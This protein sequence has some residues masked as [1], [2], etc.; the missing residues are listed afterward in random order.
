MVLF[1][2]AINILT[3]TVLHIMGSFVGRMSWWPVRLNKFNG[4][5]FV[6]SFQLLATQNYRYTSQPGGASSCML[7]AMGHV[8]PFDWQLHYCYCLCCCCICTS[9][10]APWLLSHECCDPLN[11]LCRQSFLSLA[12]FCQSLF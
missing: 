9:Y 7:S 8:M 6:V 4:S 12:W 2:Q 3:G 11:V 10:F 5:S 1:F